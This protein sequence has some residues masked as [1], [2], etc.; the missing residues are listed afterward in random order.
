MSPVVSTCAFHTHCPSIKGTGL[1]MVQKLREGHDRPSVTQ[2]E[3]IPTLSQKTLRHLGASPGTC[4]FCNHS[5]CPASLSIGKAALGGLAPH[6]MPRLLVCS[7]SGPVSSLTASG[8]LCV[9]CCLPKRPLHT[10]SHPVDS[11]SRHWFK[12]N[13]LQLTLC[14]SPSFL[15]PPFPGAPVPAPTLIHLCGYVYDRF[16]LRNWLGTP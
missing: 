6:F 11:S 10:C 12:S 14:D 7:F 9:L 16:F 5:L 15:T 3:H 13:V 8:P 2:Q 1:S 4:L